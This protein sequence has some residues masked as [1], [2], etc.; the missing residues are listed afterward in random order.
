MVGG[1]AFLSFLF[2]LIQLLVGFSMEKQALE[3]LEKRLKSKTELKKSTPAEEKQAEIKF[4][5][6]KS[7]LGLS[8]T[9]WLRLAFLLLLLVVICSVLVIWISRRGHRPYPKLEFAW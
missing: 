6:A 2:L 1:L 3:E 5:V 4:G 8:R 9:I 7:V